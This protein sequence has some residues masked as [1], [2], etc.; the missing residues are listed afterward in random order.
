MAKLV[1]KKMANLIVDIKY[2]KKHGIHRKKK[3]KNVIK[4]PFKK[5]Y[6]KLHDKPMIG[7]L[8]RT[9]LLVIKLPNIDDR[10]NQLQISDDVLRKRIENIMKGVNKNAK[11]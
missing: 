4:S 2:I 1:D 10:I 6:R 11:S 3:I 8:L 7:R 9:I 5:I